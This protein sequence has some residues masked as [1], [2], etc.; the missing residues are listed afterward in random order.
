MIVNS[1]PQTLGEAL[2][3]KKKKRN[4]RRAV[5]IKWVLKAEVDHVSIQT[6]LKKTF[7]KNV[8]VFVT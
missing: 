2:P 7:L 5:C 1:I 8:D 4:N 6:M 3:Y